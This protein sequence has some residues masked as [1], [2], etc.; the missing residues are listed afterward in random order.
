MATTFFQRAMIGLVLS[1]ALAGTTYAQIRYNKLKSTLLI[2]NP[3]EFKRMGEPVV[4]NRTYLQKLLGGPWQPN[5]VPVLSYKGKP[6]PYQLDD[7]AGSPQWD[8]L[9]FQIDL[10]ANETG[11]VT[12]SWA[13]AAAAPKFETATHARLGVSAKQ[14]N[15][16]ET[17]KQEVRPDDWKPQQMPQRY[18]ME[19]P[20]WENDVVAF[21]SY[22]DARNGKDIFGKRNPELI[23]DK[24][25]IPNTPLGNYHKLEDWGMDI[26]KVAT[27][28]GAG[29]IGLQ[30]G[31]SLYP[32]GQ[33][34]RLEYKFVTEGPC[35]A[36]LKLNN[37]GWQVPGEPLNSEEYIT[38]WKGKY[39]YENRV[40]LSGQKDPKT[41]ITGV[42]YV[43]HPNPKVV[44]SKD[45]SPAPWLAT[46]AKQSENNDLLGMAVIFPKNLFNGFADATAKTKRITTTYYGKMRVLPGQSATYRFI[47]GWE[48]S[49]K[50]FADEAQWK[51]YVQQEANVMA[52]PL[53]IK[54]K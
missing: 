26:L 28:L 1:A 31:D 9:A 30:I 53:T 37:T 38:I 45:D 5:L 23:I 47:S 39:W 36:I 3:S 18:Q 46:H 21:R 7:V 43:H 24:I 14:D 11:F 44:Q 17:V 8:E 25:G 29:A 15:T 22:F 2:T 40:T 27:S 19:G 13:D 10:G 50:R 52:A 12:I 32:I 6:L 20:G 54:A 41:L 48:M 33:S 51:A 42:T 49:D 35:R 34:K 4:L 16:F